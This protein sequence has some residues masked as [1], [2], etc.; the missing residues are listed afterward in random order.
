LDGVETWSHHNPVC[1]PVSIRFSKAALDDFSSWML[2]AL[3]RVLD[4]HPLTVEDIK[5]RELREKTE[6]FGPYYFILVGWR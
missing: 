1:I 6:P 3:S 5:T 4:I 2:D